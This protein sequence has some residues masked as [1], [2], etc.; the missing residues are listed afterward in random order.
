[1]LFDLNNLESTPFGIATLSGNK[2]VVYLRQWLN[3][4]SESF[5]ELNVVISLG[6]LTTSRRVTCDYGLKTRG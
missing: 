5:Y 2:A 1:M 4:D 6:R 3:A